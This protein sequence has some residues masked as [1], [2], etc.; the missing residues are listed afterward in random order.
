MVTDCQTVTIF[1]VRY[2]KAGV[3]VFQRSIDGVVCFFGR[4]SIALCNDILSIFLYLF[5]CTA[6][7]NEVCS[8]FEFCRSKK[9]RRMGREKSFRLRDLM[10][11][12]RRGSDKFGNMSGIRANKLVFY[13][14]APIVQIR[15]FRSRVVCTVA[16]HKYSVLHY[17]LSL[18]LL[19]PIRLLPD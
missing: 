3:L 9:C 14:L 10:N 13:G 6:K 1:F 12:M 4:L 19:G 8:V 15:M 11:F 7:Y 17:L 18:F 5:P 2:S 16:L